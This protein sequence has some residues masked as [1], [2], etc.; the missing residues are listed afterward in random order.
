MYGCIFAKPSARVNKTLATFKNERIML[1]IFDFLSVNE[2][3]CVFFPAD[4]IL[5]K[6]E[7]DI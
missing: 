2:F 6:T 7:N 4:Y 5:R 1:G 3:F